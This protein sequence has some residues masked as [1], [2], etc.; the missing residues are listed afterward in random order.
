MSDKLE[1]IVCK[2]AP[3]GTLFLISGSQMQCMKCRSTFPGEFEH[4]CAHGGTERD[5]LQLAVALRGLG[6]DVT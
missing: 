6:G 2:D 4:D 5:V 1:F 3:P